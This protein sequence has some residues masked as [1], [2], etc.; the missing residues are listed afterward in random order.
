MFKK[1][2]RFGGVAC[3]SGKGATH[4][5]SAARRALRRITG[6]NWSSSFMVLEEL[7]DTEQIVN[8]F[9]AIP[10]AAQPRAGGIRMS[11]LTCGPLRTTIAASWGR[12][13]APGPRPAGMI[14]TSFA[15]SI[16]R[17]DIPALQNSAELGPQPMLN[18]ILFNQQLG[19]IFVGCLS[20][21]SQNR[22]WSYV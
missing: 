17:G 6:V 2:N 14:G 4:S 18:G 15:F 19:L 13:P 12:S 3:R 8:V 11:C 22:R 20:A 7:H 1:R 5:L 10:V 9:L 16:E 21:K